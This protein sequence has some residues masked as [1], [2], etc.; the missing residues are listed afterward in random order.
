[1]LKQD[2]VDA[3]VERRIK[4]RDSEGRLHEIDYAGHSRAQGYNIK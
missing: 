1:M 3:N 2:L 4:L